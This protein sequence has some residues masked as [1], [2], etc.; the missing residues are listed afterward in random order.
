MGTKGWAVVSRGG[1]EEREVVGRE[2]KKTVGERKTVVVSERSGGGKGD[3][4]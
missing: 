3:K 2:V 1:R 4:W